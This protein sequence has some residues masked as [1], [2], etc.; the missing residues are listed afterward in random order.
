MPNLLPAWLTLPILVA[1]YKPLCRLLPG[2]NKGAYVRR[3][4]EAG[5]RFYARRF[6]RIPYRRRMLFLPYCLRHPRCPTSIDP[7]QGLICPDQCDLECRLR[8][9]RQ[10]ALE[11]GY[12]KAYIVVSGRLHK[13]QGAVRSR[14]F[15]VRRIEEFQPQ[16]VIGCLCTRDLREKYLR[17][18]T[19]S[20]GGTLG[21][22]G[23][24]VIPQVLLLEN[25]RCKGSKVDW[26][27]LDEL[28]RSR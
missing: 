26:D 8:Q 12:S 24:Q 21:R 28:I 20:P 17:P 6:R 5:N 23:T 7:D 14:N 3:T 13:D 11:L 10:L 18:D 16:G 1:L 15:L 2:L 4:V 19:I 9:S 27:K 25:S 22:Q